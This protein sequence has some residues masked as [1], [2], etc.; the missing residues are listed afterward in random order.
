VPI[1]AIGGITSENG[2]AL[3]DA[4]ADALAVI[5]AIF[6]APDIAASAARF[7]PLFGSK[8]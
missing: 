3:V 5:S 7:G 2:G 4:G 1:V 8:R 6:D